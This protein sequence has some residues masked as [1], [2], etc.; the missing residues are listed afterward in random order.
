MSQQGTAVNEHIDTKFP[1]H[2]SNLYNLVNNF[3]RVSRAPEE[4]I[5]NESM[6]M[7]TGRENEKPP[8]RITT[9]RRKKVKLRIEKFPTLYKISH[10]FYYILLRVPAIFCY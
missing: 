3:W 6:C 5:Y 2:N 10:P 1:N 4:V 7:D 9:R 8:P